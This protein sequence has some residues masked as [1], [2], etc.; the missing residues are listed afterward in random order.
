[1]SQEKGE[2]HPHE[3]SAAD[4]FEAFHQRT[5]GYVWCVLGRAGIRRSAERCELAQEV[6]LVAHQ[7][8]ATRD[9]SAPELLWVGRIARHL[10]WRYGAL[11][12]TQREQPVDQPDSTREPIATGPSAEEM[13]IRRAQYLEIMAVLDE[14]HREVFEMHEV[15]GWTLAEI[16]A[17]LKKPIGTV[18]TQIRRASETIAA[19]VRRM[20][21][22]EAREG[23]AMALLPVGLGTG[24]WREAGKVFDDATPAMEDQV[25]RGVR[26]GLARAA[27]LGG[28][29]AVGA[30]AISKGLVFGSGLLVGGGVVG[31]VFALHLFSAPPPP[32][33]PI[34]PAPEVASVAITT[35]SSAPESVAAA[36]ASPA[37]TQVAAA[38][39]ASSRPVAPSLA[40][41]D[42]EEE[43]ILSRA[44][45]AFARGN[46]GAAKSALDDH[47]RRF[48]RGALGAERER[49]RSKLTSS[50]PGRARDAGRAP[51]R[52]MGTDDED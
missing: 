3:N 19:A 47:G 33:L 35:T 51:N 16:A 37:P 34:V 31:A 52:L 44:E 1:M 27:V 24:A 36:P 6:Y 42:P 23:R 40:G 10:A 39:V 22:R 20:E 15:E 4:D 9:P 29:A 12:R 28:T 11:G 30:S 2:P 43:R 14:A 50:D 5:F 32:A 45:S 8:R 7:K 18:S 48:P 25:W 46:V 41:I 26:L 38:P 21:V 13:A 17:A 49:L